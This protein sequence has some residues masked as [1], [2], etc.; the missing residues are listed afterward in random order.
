MFQ[1]FK[2]LADELRDISNQEQLGITIRWIDDQLAINENF[3]GLINLT[4]AD[5]NSVKNAIKDTLLRALLPL[6][7]CRGQGYDGVSTM[8]GAKNGVAA[9]LCK[10]ELRAIYVHCLAHCLNLILQDTSRAC[11]IIRDGLEL[12]MGIAQLIN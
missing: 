9:Q 5:T 2:I 7:S 8:K 11:T 3:I 1:W 4:M 10:E 12:C 6:S